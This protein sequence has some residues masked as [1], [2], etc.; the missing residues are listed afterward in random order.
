MCALAALGTVPGAAPAKSILALSGPTL[1]PHNPLLRQ[2]L[3]P[4]EREV[5]N[6]VEGPSNPSRQIGFPSCPNDPSTFAFEGKQPM[7]G[8]ASLDALRA[9]TDE[10]LLTRY[11]QAD[12]DDDAAF[13]ELN[14]R[15]EKR[16]LRQVRRFEGGVLRSEAGDIVQEVY[17]EF[18]ENRKGYAPQNVGALLR[19][20]VYHVCLK[21][22]E[23]ATAAKRNYQLTVHPDGWTD[24][25]AADDGHHAGFAALIPDAK[26]DPAHRDAK[27]ELDEIL[28][29]CLPPEQ[30][31]AVRITRIEGHTIEEAGKLLDLKPKTVHK[32]AE[33]GIGNLKKW[34]STMVI[35]LALFGTVF[36]N[37]D[38][39]VVTN[40]CTAEED[41]DEVCRD[42][43][44]SHHDSDKQRR[45]SLM[46]WLDRPDIAKCC[47]VLDQT[48]PSVHAKF[49]ET[50]L[51]VSAPPRLDRSWR[52]RGE[53]GGVLHLRTSKATGDRPPVPNVVLAA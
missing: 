34:A 35:L 16:L 22:V 4:A 25:Y 5:G 51:A 27:I 45:K 17:A 48:H 37:C 6:F 3:T 18:H 23:K 47:L 49:K 10:N 41:V 8:T 9:A 52:D 31:E 36:N 50:I 1:C 24:Q 2:S 19:R 46:G 29:N 44:G 11:Q 15:Y 33:R 7:A 42:D 43:G 12:E 21:H 28:D 40:M 32:R 20:I 13:E 30:A 53:N 14:R 26:A 38:L 39:D